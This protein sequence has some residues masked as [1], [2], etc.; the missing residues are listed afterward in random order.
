[1]RLAGE[2]GLPVSLSL[3]VREG[4]AGAPWPLSGGARFARLIDEAA[5]RRAFMTITSAA[6]RQ[7]PEASVAGC[8]VQAATNVP[9]GGFELAVG[10]TRDPQ[11]GPL[12]SFGQAGIGSELLGDTSYRLAPLTPEDARE[13]LR[14]VR[15]YPLLRGVQGGAV[16]PLEALE[17]LLLALSRLALR[18]PRLAGAQ[19]G[20]VL[21]GA[22][23][24]FVAGARLTLA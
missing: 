2:I 10:F 1:V 19:L 3:A 16:V 15:F 20:P 18:A 4:G 12:L 11:F 7:Q 5:V 21:A 8:L 24:V 6:A 13:M 23:G 17:R 9:R 14:E 22:Q